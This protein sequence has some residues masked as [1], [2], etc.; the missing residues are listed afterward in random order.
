MMTRRGGVTV[1]RSIGRMR[2]GTGPIRGVTTLPVSGLFQV[3]GVAVGRHG[4]VYESNR[5]DSIAT[6]ATAGQ[7]LKITG[8]G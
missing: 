2:T 7:V 1:S 3:T 4:A 5:G 8:L 6:D